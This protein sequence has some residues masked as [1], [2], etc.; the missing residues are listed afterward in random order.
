MT[1][2]NGVHWDVGLKISLTRG[3]TSNLSKYKKIV[4]GLMNKKI[5]VMR[6][7]SVHLFEYQITGYLIRVS[8]LTPRECR[9][10]YVLSVGFVTPL[11]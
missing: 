6:G 9:T 7:P 3:G 8:F 4:F 1:S 10:G 11:E 2:G 5:C